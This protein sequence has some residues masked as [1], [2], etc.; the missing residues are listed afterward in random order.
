M[1]IKEIQELLK[2]VKKNGFGE[3]NLEDGDFKLSVKTAAEG[4]PVAQASIMPQY[5]PI[6]MPM[7]AANPAPAAVSAPAESTPAN[8]ES[9]NT[10]S[11]LVEIKSPIVGTF[12]RSAG[13]DKPPFLKVGDDVAVGDVVCIVEAMKLF[14]EIESEVS[15]K[16]VKVMMED[17]Q[18]VQYD[19]VLFLVEP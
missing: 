14:N 17:A 10:A 16:I 5:Q 1:D 15:G 12:Y 19:Q 9:E 2:F 6:A 13:P 11:T 3:F 4:K 18:P 8:P 7:P